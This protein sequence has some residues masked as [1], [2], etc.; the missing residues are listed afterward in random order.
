MKT[1]CNESS[2]NPETPYT[3]MIAAASAGFVS[4]TLTNPIWFIK[5]RL[6][7]DQ[8]Q[9]GQTTALTCIKSIYNESG[10]KG[11]YKGITAR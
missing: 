1:I 8:T 3:H 6:Q 5:T 4:S 10:I 11:F 2:K 7:L 9:Y